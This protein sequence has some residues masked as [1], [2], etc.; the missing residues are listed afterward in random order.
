MRTIIAV[1]AILCFE[2]CAT[3]PQP[4]AEWQ[5]QKPF[6][7]GH[8]WSAPAR[9]LS[10]PAKQVRMIAD[11]KEPSE[12]SLQQYLDDADELKGER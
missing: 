9:K 7:I 8:A 6:K 10:K 3:S 1:A 4:I 2:A 5:K 11:Y 12:G